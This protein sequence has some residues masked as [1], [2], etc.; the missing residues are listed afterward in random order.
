MKILKPYFVFALG[1]L[2]GGLIARIYD[3]LHPD[4][5]KDDRQKLKDGSKHGLI[6]V[7]PWNGKLIRVHSAG[8]TPKKYLFRWPSK[9][10]QRGGYGNY[11]RAY[12]ELIVN[13]HLPLRS[14]KTFQKF[15]EM[16]PE[17]LPDPALFDIHH[18][19]FIDAMR[20][21]KKD[22]GGGKRLKN[23]FTP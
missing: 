2:A 8:N 15:I 21:R 19:R 7:T 4:R 6:Y 13:Q 16:F 20:K 17:E 22:R 3:L 18:P 9:R 12:A 5:L 11:D 23:A 10:K 14:K 1:M